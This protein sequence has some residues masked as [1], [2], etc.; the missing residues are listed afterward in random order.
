MFVLC[1]FADS[2]RGVENGFVGA[3]S[4]PRPLELKLL[5]MT[6]NR[7][8]KTWVIQKVARADFS[9]SSSHWQMK[10][11]IISLGL[12]K[13]PKPVRWPRA[14]LFECHCHEQCKCLGGCA[15]FLLSRSA[16]L[17]RCPAFRP[18]ILQNCQ[19]T[20]SDAQEVFWRTPFDL[21]SSWVG[22]RAVMG[23]LDSLQGDWVNGISWA[24]DCKA[25]LGPGVPWV[26]GS[27]VN[28]PLTCFLELL[29]PNL[30]HDQGHLEEG[31][32]HLWVPRTHHSR[33]TLPGS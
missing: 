18:S 19:A 32:L 29:L 22:G 23:H 4:E 30:S 15:H 33:L 27:V 9:R 13:L 10:H 12:F 14:A 21:E 28:P 7:F 5:V 25:A 20:G 26:W 24:F 1:P 2:M 8:L 31:L 3:V 17:W 6:K 11:F 16:Q